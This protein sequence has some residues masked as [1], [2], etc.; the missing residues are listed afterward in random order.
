MGSSRKRRKAQRFGGFCQKAL[1]LK[2]S[3]SFWNQELSVDR[4]ELALEAPYEP[5]EL[6]KVLRSTCSALPKGSQIISIS[7][8]KVAEQGG[9]GSRNEQF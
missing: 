4:T 6:E 7:G 3:S 5:E 1:S 2:R 9:P 8:S